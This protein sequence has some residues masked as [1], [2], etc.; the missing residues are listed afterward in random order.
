[1]KRTVVHYTHPMLETICGVHHY[2]KDPP[3]TTDETKITCGNCIKKLFIYDFDVERAIKE[4]IPRIKRR[5]F[6][7]NVE[8]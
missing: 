6:A 4:R 3:T 1:M 5:C 2:K 8:K 7:D